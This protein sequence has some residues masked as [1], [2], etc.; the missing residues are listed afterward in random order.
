VKSVEEV[1]QLMVIYGAGF[2]AVFVLFCAPSCSCVEAGGRAG[3]IG[4]RTIRHASV[5]I[6]NGLSASVGLVSIGLALL[7][8]AR[9]A[10]IA[11]F[12]YCLLGVVHTLCGRRVRRTRTRMATVARAIHGRAEAL[13]HVLLATHGRADA[14]PHVLLAT[15]GRVEACPTDCWRVDVLCMSQNR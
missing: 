13:P 8:P 3:P 6:R 9:L 11:G 4:Q 12:S 14:L 1:R 2:V 7:L 15:H 10:G 5:A